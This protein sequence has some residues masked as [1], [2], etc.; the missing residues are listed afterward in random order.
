MV[1]AKGTKANCSR[2]MLVLK[3]SQGDKIDKKSR[4]P[5]FYHH[6]YRA[7]DMPEKCAFKIVYSAEDPAPKRSNSAVLSLCRIE[8]DWDKPITEWQ[9]VGDPSEGW[10]KHNDLELTMGLQGEPKWE[11]RVGS[12]K[13]EHKFDIE[14]AS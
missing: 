12:N 13:R 4:I 11:V 8:C 3:P 2:R 14:Y 5:F 9:P 7:R 10:R 1:L 6:Y